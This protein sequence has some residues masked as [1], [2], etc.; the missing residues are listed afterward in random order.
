MALLVWMKNHRPEVYGN[1]QW[2]FECMDYVRYR[3][4]DEVCGELT[5]YSGTG[6][7]KLHTRDYDP[8]L[9]RL[10]GI[11]EIQHA[12][13]PLRASTDICGTVTEEAAAQCGLLPGTPVIGGMFDIDACALAVNV[14]DEDHICMIS[15]T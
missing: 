1:I 4:T 8:A 11:E 9:L 12:L 10:F 6:L 13:P 2:V 14:L 3:L 7:V 5:D 15:G